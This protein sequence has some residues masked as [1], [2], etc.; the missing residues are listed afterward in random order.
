[1]KKYLILLL[2]SVSVFF[3]C[4][5][6]ELERLKQQNDSLQQVTGQKDVK[7]NEFFQAFNEIQSNLDEIKQKE[8]I[9]AVQSNSDKP[10]EQ[11]A[12]E[13]INQ[14]ILSMYELM[15]KNKKSLAALNKKLKNS[16]VKVAELEKTIQKLTEAMAQKDADLEKMKAALEKKDMDI[17]NLNSQ[18]KEMDTKINEVTTDANTKQEVI[19]TQDEQLNTAYYV[20]GNKKELKEN[21][22]IESDG[23]FK[24]KIGSDFNKD[25]FKKIDIRK[26]TNIPISGGKK[27][28]ILSIHPSSSYYFDE[29]DKKVTALVIKDPQKFWET[30]KYLVILV[31]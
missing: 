15:L 26:M 5:N 1:M 18:I 24:K 23:L 4:N 14:D 11:S 9:I 2:V 8:Q 17:A 28:S 20:S 25:Y 31:E 29:K 10:I 30:S 19:N 6:A 13:K 21:K 7:V 12:K 3:S 16:N 22:I 27:A